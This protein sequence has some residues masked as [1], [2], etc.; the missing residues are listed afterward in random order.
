[1][2]VVMIL[3]AVLLIVIMAVL[4]YRLVIYALPALLGLAVARL[5][6]AA[7]AG[8]GGAGIAGLIAGMLSFCVLAV[9]FAT[10]RKPVMCAAIALI[11]VT[12]AVMAGYILT[13]ALAESLVPS[14]IWRQILCLAVSALIGSSAFARLAGAAAQGGANAPKAESRL[15]R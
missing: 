10:A 9:L 7:G 6:D 4:A 3:V 13:Y 8:W 14:A 15:D 5:A 2:I 11:F 1:M 12:P